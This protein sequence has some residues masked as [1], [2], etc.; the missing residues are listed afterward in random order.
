[1]HLV[2]LSKLNTIREEFGYINIKELWINR[3]KNLRIN[4]LFLKNKDGLQL[5]DQ[6]LK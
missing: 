3:V 6:F 4:N 1:L 2:K 5:Q